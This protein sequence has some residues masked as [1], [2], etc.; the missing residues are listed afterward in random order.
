M[1]IAVD[2]M[3]GDRAPDVVVQGALQAAGETGT[4][5][6]LVGNER[7]IR[8]ALKRCGRKG[9]VEIFPCDEFVRMDE[10]PMKA[11]RRKPNA[12]VRVAFDLVKGGKADAVVSAGNSGATFAAGLLVLGKVGGV[13]RPALASIFP[14]RAGEVV[15]IDVGANVDCRPVHLLQFGQMAQAFATACLGMANPAVGL[16]SIGEE[17][18]KGN[19]QVRKAHVL[20]KESRLNFVGNVEGRDI[21]TGAV[22]IIVC[23][24]FVGNVAL[25]VAEGLSETM[26]EMVEKEMMRT[27]HGRLGFRMGRSGFRKLFET[28]DHETYGGAPILGINGVGIVCHGS[29]SPRA[30]KNGVKRAAE[31][32]RDGFQEKL[33]LRMADFNRV[34]SGC[35]EAAGGRTA[36]RDMRR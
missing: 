7:A 33:A 24:G 10:S 11:I 5:V 25:K 3:G 28:M 16:L 21:F 20:L 9:P 14:G 29:A 4:T 31:Y 8:T 18:E 32:V 17:G 36:G 19:E 6:T 12:S 22:P 26:A 35:P 13:D 2:A 23:D 30:V 34:P 15:L 27:F 1:N